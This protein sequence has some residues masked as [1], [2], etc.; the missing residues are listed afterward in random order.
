MSSGRH[1]RLL[2]RERKKEDSRQRNGV[3]WGGGADGEK[4]VQITA[5]GKVRAQQMERTYKENWES[6][7]R[8]TQ[9][10]LWVPAGGDQTG[11]AV[12]SNRCCG[13]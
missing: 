3:Q 9:G 1:D 4:V 10:R 12:I 13:Q 7:V 6:S 8:K 2:D 11:V 5:T